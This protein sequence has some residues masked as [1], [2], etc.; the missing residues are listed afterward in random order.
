[1]LHLPVI[2]NSNREIRKFGF[3]ISFP[4]CLCLCVLFSFCRDSKIRATKFG[5]N[6]SKDELDLESMKHWM[7]RFINLNL[8][9]HFHS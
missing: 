7:N 8:G 5:A 1:M 3:Q 2:S 9:M 4:G 6:A